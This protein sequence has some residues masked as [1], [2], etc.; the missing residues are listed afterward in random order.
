V[1]ARFVGHP[2]ADLIADEVDAGEARDRLGLARDGQ[3]VALLPGSRVGEVARLAQPF[4]EAAAWCRQ[5]QPGLS[6][7]VPLAGSGCRAT[8]EVAWQQHAPELPLT[9]LDGHGLEAMAA[10]DAVLLA[11]GTAT[12]ECMLLK[13][14]M[15]VAYR[16][17]PLTYRLARRL[18]RTP[19]FALP[20]LLA[21]RPLVAE[22]IQHEVTA[23]RLGAELLRL[24]EDPARSER[25]ER[26][27]ANLHAELRR[28][29]SRT[30]AEAVMQLV[31]TG[32][33]D[34]D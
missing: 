14:P 8:F 1:P 25:L 23:T 31:A 21:G 7:V 16:L 3:V 24:L 32:H 30:A 10:A 19:Y 33:C 5:R 15:V 6:F 13:R 34:G 12:L 28:N 2:L 11:S 17:S 26:V 18:V 22:L 29:A 9:L 20:N 27:F 4:I